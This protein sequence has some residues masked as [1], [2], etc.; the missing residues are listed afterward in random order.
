V[1]RKSGY[2]AAL[3]AVV[4]IGCTSHGKTTSVQDKPDGKT[5][6]EHRYQYIRLVPQ[7]HCQ[8]ADT[9]ANSHPQDLGGR[10]RAA[11]TALRIDLPDQEKTVPVF[12]RTELEQ[13]TGP[14]LQAFR[15]AAP[16]EDVAL[17]IEAP[18]PGRFG[19]Q[20][21]ITTARMFIQK[22]DELHVIFGK[23]HVPV[24]DYGSGWHIEPTDYR[25]EPL[26]PGSRCRK[27]GEKIPAL[28]TTQSV[29]F[30][31]QEGTPRKDWL[32]VSLTAQPSQPVPTPVP[33][34]VATPAAPQPPA[35][36]VPPAASELPAVTA[37]PPEPQPR[38]VT[39]PPAVQD[40][41]RT[42][43]PAV[44]R[45]EKSILKRLQILKDLRV[46]GL[47]NEQEYLDKKQEILDSL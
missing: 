36:T 27:A 24:D 1:I 11:L 46:K 12:T 6:W 47:I 15:M 40:A 43:P 5:I 4:V 18:H 8:G 3:L 22:G 13:V 29:S 19:F 39:P 25:L 35:V 33:P 32:A 26:E 9:I 7:D 16:D 37:T 20:R 30:H 2:L 10:L 21:A 45:S 14:L 23:L 28:I 31:E 34:P 44:H 41:S 38:M 17:A 42:T